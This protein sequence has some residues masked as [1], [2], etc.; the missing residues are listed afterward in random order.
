[1]SRRSRRT[2]PARRRDAVAAAA[3]F[4]PSP[5]DLGLRPL[6][7]SAD[8]ASRRSLLITAMSQELRTPMNAILGYAHLLLEDRSQ[9]LTSQQR[10]DIRQLQTSAKRLAHA[11]DDVIELTRLECGRVELAIESTDMVALAAEARRRVLASTALA[12]DRIT[13]SHAEGPI[14]ADVDPMRLLDACVAIVRDLL[15]LSPNRP[16]TIAIVRDGADCEVTIGAEPDAEPATRR[17]ARR[18]A[19]ALPWG[20]PALDIAAAARLVELLHGSFAVEGNP[21]A[22]SRVIMRLPL[23][24]NER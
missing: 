9:Q 13:L 8:A 5:D 11:I 12:D 18:P 3:F 7:A 22:G 14:C 4:A 21:D 10:E 15:R 23:T 16:L 17:P 20:A 6:A 2:T 24:P 19:E 1:M